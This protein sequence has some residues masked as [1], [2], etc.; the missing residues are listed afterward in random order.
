MKKFMSDFPTQGGQ[1]VVALLLIFITG[2]IVA[3]RLLRG[4]SFPDGYE[5][6]LFF[7]G[8]LA[9]VANIGM[10]GKRFTDFRYKQAG[11]SPVNV[12]APSQVNVEA[13]PAA[14]RPPSPPPAPLPP[15]VSITPAT[16]E[17]SRAQSDTT[18]RTQ[19]DD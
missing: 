9:G 16:A 3:G 11:T 4:L 14:P 2:L 6:W 12:E 5:A 10:I 7:L 17:V 18:T 15:G 13:P 8:A 19:P 1:V